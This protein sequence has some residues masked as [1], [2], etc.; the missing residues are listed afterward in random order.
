MFLCIRVM[1]GADGAGIGCF[2][3]SASVDL[4][5]WKTTGGSKYPGTLCDQRL[6][7]VFDQVGVQTIRGFVAYAAAAVDENLLESLLGPAEAAWYT[8]RSYHWLGVYWRPRGG[9]YPCGA[10]SEA[11]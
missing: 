11:V 5:D 6:C 10:E 8:L 3:C 1:V 9:A 2:D 7:G 4:L